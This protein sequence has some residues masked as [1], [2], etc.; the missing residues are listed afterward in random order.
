MVVRCWARW[1][2]LCSGTGKGHR[3]GRGTHVLQ[4][5]KITLESQPTLPLY[6]SQKMFTIISFNIKFTFIKSLF[7]FEGIC[8]MVSFGDTGGCSLSSLKAG[9]KVLVVE[10]HSVCGGCAPR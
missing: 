7:F 3:I 6:T 9:R 1:S 4:S 8:E 2:C 5:C 10:A